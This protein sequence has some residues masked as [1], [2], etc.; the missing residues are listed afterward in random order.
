MESYGDLLKRT[1]EARAIDLDTASYETTITLPYLTALESEDEGVFPGEPYMLGFM[2]TY[3]Q[4]LGLSPDNLCALYRAKK[5]QEAP[6]PE[7]LIVHEKPRYYWPVIIVAIIAVMSAMGFGI[8]YI[9][10]MHKA[11]LEEAAKSVVA[12]DTVKTATYE[13]TDNAQNLRVYVGDQFR[14]DGV[15]LTVSDTMANLGIICPVGTLYTALSEENALDVDGDNKSDII[16]YVSDISLTD[17]NRGAQV[18]VLRANGLG[19]DVL[20]AIETIDT[21]ATTAELGNHKPVEV[22]RD[23]R[24]YPFTL[25]GNFRGSCLFRYKVD[26][27]EAFETYFTTGEI[28]TMTANNGIRLWISNS[29][30][31]K[32]SVIADGRNYDL[33][34]GKAGQV[35]F[36]DVKWIKDT[37]DGKYKLVIIEGD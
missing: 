32:L 19:A 29:N 7:G 15:V 31:V 1:R 37:A 23:N 5:L 24:A 10:K 20:A 22:F 27:K 35:L 11:S 14:L 34:I 25:N 16:V 18:R 3:A 28:V 17:S 30:A 36:E 8:L 9:L 21:S 33:A 6:T 2:R 13:I 26:R 4:Y 12:D